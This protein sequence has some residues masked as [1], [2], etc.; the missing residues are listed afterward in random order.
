MGRKVDNIERELINGII[1][2]SFVEESVQCM[3][4]QEPHVHLN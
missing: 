1:S 3:Y 2:N 4:Q